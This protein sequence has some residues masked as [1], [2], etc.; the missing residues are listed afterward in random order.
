[1]KLKALWIAFLLALLGGAGPALADELPKVC[2]NAVVSGTTRG[3]IRD[4]VAS[5]AIVVWAAE[6]TSGYTL[7]YA[8]WNNARRRDVSCRRYT[9]ALGLNLWE[10]TASAVPCRLR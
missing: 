1:L 9:S 10:C 8:N 6:A 5:R 7:R 2:V 3:P 4:T